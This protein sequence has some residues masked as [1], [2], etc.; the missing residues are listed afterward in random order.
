M[1]L[2]WLSHYVKYVIYINPNRIQMVIFEFEVFRDSYK[3]IKIYHKIGSNNIYIFK[4][5]F[6]T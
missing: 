2:Q 6:T 4:P 3:I 1:K 5:L